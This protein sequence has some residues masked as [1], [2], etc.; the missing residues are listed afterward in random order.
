MK[1]NK[2]LTHTHI[3]YVIPIYGGKKKERNCHKNKRTWI[4]NTKW[5]YLSI[6]KEEYLPL[7]QLHITYD[8]VFNL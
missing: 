3:L 2:Q 5:R 4:Q 7:E 1:E 8:G 6:N